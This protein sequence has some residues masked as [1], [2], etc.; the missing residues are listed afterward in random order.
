VL[1]RGHG[2]VQAVEQRLGVAR[3]GE[4]DAFQA[5]VAGPGRERL[6]RLGVEHRGPG[7]Q[8]L[9]ELRRLGERPLDLPVGLVELEQDLRRLPEVR[10]RDD[11]GLHPGPAVRARRADREQQAPDRR[12]H[13]QRRDERVDPQ[14]VVVPRAQG[15]PAQLRDPAAVLRRL[16]PLRGVRADGVHVG[17]RVGDVTGQPGVGGLPRV[18]EDLAAADE[19]GHQ[20]PGD[21]DHAQQH[22]HQHRVVAPEHHRREDQRQE[23]ADD[24][25][26]Q[27]VDEGLVLLREAQHPFGE[28]TREV[29]VEEDRVLRQQRLHPR[30][31]EP[32]DAV[33]LHPV[34]AVDAD[35]PERLAGEHRGEEPE[36]VGR[37][38]RG[39][40]PFARGQPADQLPDEQ[41]RQ[42]GHA[43]V[44]HGG[45]QQ[46][47][48]AQ[49]LVAAQLGRVQA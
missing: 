29:L 46:R 26:H 42:V 40:D 35:A 27:G 2:E 36:H 34:Q 18:D 11:D 38:D 10:D 47:G 45:Q 12:G 23:L 3:V 43:D 9:G 19:R 17:H 39:R 4:P 49:R 1:A 41:R 30:H 33:G 21:R 22:D 8:Q 5:H 25:E 14:V 7:Q 48:A 44:A 6:R 24:P 15:Q 20:H 16:P 37:D 32:G 28:R 13:R 31:V